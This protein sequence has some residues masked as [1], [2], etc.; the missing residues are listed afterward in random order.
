MNGSSVTRQA[1][2]NDGNALHRFFRTKREEPS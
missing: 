1:A 2:E